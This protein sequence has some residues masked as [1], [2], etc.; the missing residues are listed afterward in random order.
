M[1]PGWY[2]GA[3]GSSR[4]PGQDKG[5]PCRAGR[6]LR[7][8]AGGSRGPNRTTIPLTSSQTS[9]AVKDAVAILIDSELWGFVTPAD[10]DIEAVTEA[11]K[12]V[13]PY[14]AVPTKWLAIDELPHTA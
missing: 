9:P 4:R 1:A 6:S 5:F 2:I 8:Y 13:Q 10:A 14:Y 3:L 12:K 7:S 11:T